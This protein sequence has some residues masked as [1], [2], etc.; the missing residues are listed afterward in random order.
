MTRTDA[1]GTAAATETWRAELAALRNELLTVS[2]LEEHEERPWEEFGG[3]DDEPVLRWA[4]SLGDRLHALFVPLNRLRDEARESQ[5]LREERDKDW[6]D[7]RRIWH[8]KD[9]KVKEAE[10]E[11][12]TLRTAMSGFA[13]L[14]L[15]AYNTAEEVVLEVR[16]IARAAL[17]ASTTTQAGET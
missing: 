6:S 12:Q 15:A 14:D 3:N 7:Y 9:A 4:G 11:A 10:R 16:S 17:E 13:A 8:E 5:R 2:F 1:D